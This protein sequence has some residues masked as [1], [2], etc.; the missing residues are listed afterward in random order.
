[1]HR[2]IKPTQGSYRY[3]LTRLGR[4]VIAAALRIR[5]GA[6]IPSLAGIPA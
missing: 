3:Y 2:L 1:M 6:I 5:E 4:R